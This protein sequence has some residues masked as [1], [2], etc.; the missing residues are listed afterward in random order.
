[1]GIL[2]CALCASACKHEQVYI[3]H[4]KGRVEQKGQWQLKLIEIQVMRCR[5]S[6]GD[7]TTAGS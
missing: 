6:E 2:A 7:S 3:V 1:M 4:C 5:G